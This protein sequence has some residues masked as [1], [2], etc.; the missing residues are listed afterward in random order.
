MIQLLGFGIQVQWFKIWGVGLGMLNLLTM[1]NKE[2]HKELQLTIYFLFIFFWFWVQI[3]GLRLGFKSL[4]FKIKVYVLG[5]TVQLLGFRICD[6]D[7]GMLHFGLYWWLKL[8]EYV[9]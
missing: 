2:L 9:V 7:L 6:V 8:V 1:L 4:Y 5:F 3:Q